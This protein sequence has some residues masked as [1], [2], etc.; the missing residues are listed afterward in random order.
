MLPIWKLSEFG[1]LI[2]QNKTS[3]PSLF[4]SLF[5]FVISQCLKYSPEIPNEMRNV[6]SHEPARS[7]VRIR[8][9]GDLLPSSAE[10]LLF[11]CL[12]ELLQKQMSLEQK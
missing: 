7:T 10:L 5:F 2:I 4:C 6:I 1:L 11:L 8:I 12:Q 3:P 9:P